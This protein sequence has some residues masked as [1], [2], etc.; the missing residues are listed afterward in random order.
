VKQAA[1]VPALLV[2]LLCAAPVAAQEL[3]LHPTFPLLDA[4]GKNVLKTGAPVSPKRTCAT[5][6]D[7]EYIAGHNYHATALGGF[8]P[9]CYDAGFDIEQRLKRFGAR[10]VGGG[11]AKQLLEMNCFLCHL[12][13]A[14]DRARVGELQAGR[15]AWAATATLADTGLVRRG[16]KGWTYTKERFDEQGL[17]DLV[18]V[19]PPNRN[20]GFCH[21]PVHGNDVPFVFRAHNLEAAALTRG[22]VF[23]PQRMRDS[24]MN[25]KGKSTLARPFDV[26]AERLLRCANCHAAPNNPVYRRESAETRPEHLAFDA[27][28][29]SLAEYLRRPDHNFARGGD[30]TMR[31]CADCHYA[32]RTH[33]WLPQA[34]LHFRT[35]SCEACH[36]PHVH[37]PAAKG[38]DWTV[39]TAK[40]GPRVDY[41]GVDGPIEN[42]TSL[43]SGYEPAL[44]PDAD[45]RLAPFNLVTAWHWE[46]N[47]EPVPYPQLEEAWF[48]NGR[49]RP[50]L[51]AALDRDGDGQLSHA[52]LRL[53]NT[54]SMEAVAARLMAVGVREPRIVE[55]EQRYALHHGVA[56][57]SDAVRDCGQC[58]ARESRIGA[59]PESTD[60]YV[61]GHHRV[62]AIDLFGIGLAASVL[63]GASIHAALR[64]LAFRKR[65]ER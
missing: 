28:R 63:I 48:E 13:K 16:E 22:Q 46:S 30:G 25:L 49:Y 19:D 53:D 1:F 54:Q 3:R 26:H 4:D 41:R 23:S 15:F 27:R 2:L 39:L 7:A 31:G 55:V 42:A 38:L 12:E 65:A 6:H 5:C 32:E 35:L 21:G 59:V 43:V 44:L 9:L 36:I 52:E 56:P 47:G 64:F 8:D 10:H 61:P 60:L 33:T 29:P 24:A 20:C 40:Y 45:G 14:D 51:V 57:A 58:H 34:S 62:L 18:P 17:V 11:E 50:E 37:A